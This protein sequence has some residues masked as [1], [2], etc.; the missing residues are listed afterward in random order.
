MAN[1]NL[2]TKFDFTD[3]DG[4]L[5]SDGSTTTAKTITI[6]NGEIF[7]RTYKIASSTIT[8]ILSDDKI[9]TF[10]FL[11]IESDQAAEIQLVCNEGGTLSSDNIENG[12]V[13][14][15]N[16][17]VPFVLANDDSRNM[18]NMNGTFNESNHQSEI[19]SWETNWTADTIDRI[20]YYQ[21]TGSD[22]KVRVVA[23]G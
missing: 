22:A 8:E 7:D 1:V 14:K 12:W 11:Y 20:E 4:N 16:A 15:L 9:A 5:Y 21:T 23:I 3:A 17:G 19:D 6:T 13:V 10:D 18:G 2:Y